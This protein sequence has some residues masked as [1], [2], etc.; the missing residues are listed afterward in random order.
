MRLTHLGAEYRIS[1]Y[2]T[3]VPISLVLFG[4]YFRSFYSYFYSDDWWWLSLATENEEG[5]QAFFQVQPNGMWRPM[6]FAFF[7]YCNRLFGLDPLGYHL[8]S[9]SLHTSNVVLIY[10]V[11]RR[12]LGRKGYATLGACI[13][14]FHY[15]AY[16]P[17]TWISSVG[18]LFA[19]FFYMLSLLLFIRYQEDSNV[20][21]YIGL[22]CS[23][24]LSILASEAALSL[25]FN[26]LILGRIFYPQTFNIRR[27]KRI[28]L[29]YSPLL[30]LLMIRMA[31]PYYYGAHG[32]EFVVSK[33]KFLGLHVFT[34]LWGLL[35]ILVLPV[36][37]I[38]FL[39]DSET[40]I[41]ITRQA[42]TGC[43]VVITIVLMFKGSKEERF[44]SLWIY[45][46]A[47]PFLADTMGFSIRYAY[48]PLVG[49]S[50]VVTL[51]VFKVGRIFSLNAR[52]RI[53][54]IMF[55]VLMISLNVFMVQ[56]RISEFVI[57]G[58][59]AKR[60][61]LELSDDFRKGQK[62]RVIDNDK[63]IF[64]L[65][66]DEVEGAMY[67]LGDALVSVERTSIKYE[68]C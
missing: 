29:L 4:T 65:N 15:I 28:L 24:V 34:N 7:T 60:M 58:E 16:E 52:H 23:F 39:A 17:V 6:V 12:L 49:F 50:I 68:G 67:V 1:F 27:W 13:F 21:Y 59:R 11:T 14:G 56:R 47:L 51:L 9:I 44:F 66:K 30:V 41:Y 33:Y 53:Y 2:I 5:I 3:Y 32:A 63:S 31:I 62:E 8:I 25:L 43:L 55:L 22:L 54:L 57:R 19:L 26:V 36:M 10:T 64:G 20:R 18:H 37:R 45:I 46:A 35:S 38:P 61:F 48:F 40:I 42:L